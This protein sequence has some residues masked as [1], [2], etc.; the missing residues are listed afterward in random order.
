MNLRSKAGRRYAKAL[1]DLSSSS[2]VLEA[3]S[4]DMTRIRDNLAGISELRS[5]VGNY[6]LPSQHRAKALAAVFE[7]HLHPLVWQFVMLLES[8]RRLGLL[9]EI[10]EDFQEQEEARRGIVRGR[11]T[12]AFAM[13]PADVQE[14]AGRVGRH[15]GKQLMLES[16]ESPELLGGGRLQIG[17]QVVDFSLAAGLRRAGQ[18]MMAG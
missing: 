8:K 16:E 12:S 13:P 15:M 10:C 17:D 2:G 7:G 5:F 9:G 11:L 14:L 4:A 18:L 1:H 6:R 3:V